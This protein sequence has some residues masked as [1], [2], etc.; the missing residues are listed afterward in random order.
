M[1]DKFLRDKVN[2]DN[3]EVPESL[4]PEN[5]AK[6]IDTYDTSVEN[7]GD[8]A[9]C[10]MNAQGDDG[11]NVEKNP[12][13]HTNIKCF[14]GVA[15]HMKSF[16]LAAAAVIVVVAGASMATRINSN[17]SSGEV[18]TDECSFC[19]TIQETT[20][21]ME[22]QAAEDISMKKSKYD[23]LYEKLVQGY[24]GFDDENYILN[25]ADGYTFEDEQTGAV[26]ITR[27]TM[28]R[29]RGSPKAIFL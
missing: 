22:T 7:K 11:E 4:L 16:A 23:E 9:D 15:S 29:R 20:A 5:I 10:K 17:K 6:L 28:I 2:D 18:H 14:R 21:I 25:D 3:I 19:T 27:E 1:D 26:M 13:K 24:G 12:G 8:D